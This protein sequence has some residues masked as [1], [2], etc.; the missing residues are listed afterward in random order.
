MKQGNPE[1]YLLGEIWDVNP[2][3]VGERKFDGLMNYPLRTACIE[4]ASG[5]MLASAMKDSYGFSVVSL[6]YFNVFGKRQDPLSAY[7]AVIPI[8]VSRLLAGERPVIYGDGH[9]TRDFVFVDDVVE[10]NIGAAFHPG[11]DLSGGAY[12]IGRGERISVNGIFDIVARALGTSLRP[13]HAPPR[14][15]EIRDSV[16][17][18]S[19]ARGAFGYDP[20]V[21]VR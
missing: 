9:Q 11:D 16:A 21:D 7:A 20:K 18:I 2:R 15:G 4:F 10:A 14:P 17:D 5:E 12:N 8:F 3:W 6:R 19:A 1:A 13:D